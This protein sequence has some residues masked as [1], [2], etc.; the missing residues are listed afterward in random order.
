MFFSDRGI[1]G[2]RCQHGLYASSQGRAFSDQRINQLGVFRYIHV[3]RVS[4]LLRY[5]LILA[6]FWSGVV[7]AM[8]L[9]FIRTDYDLLREECRA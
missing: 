9:M 1:T 5:Y 4:V 3:M 6:N 8:R 2:L 7:A